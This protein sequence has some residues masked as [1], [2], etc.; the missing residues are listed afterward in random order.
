[1]SSPSV[2][3]SVTRA[4]PKG[5]PLSEKRSITDDK[6][7][8]GLNPSNQDGGSGKPKKR[9]KKNS[10]QWRMERKRKAEEHFSSMG[11]E[12]EEP[13]PFRIMTRLQKR[14]LESGL[15]IFDDRY[16]ITTG[17][18]KSRSESTVTDQTGPSQLNVTDHP[19]KVEKSEKNKYPTQNIKS[20]TCEI[21]NTKVMCT[22][23]YQRHM[24]GRKHL[25][26]VKWVRAHQVLSGADQHAGSGEPLGLYLPVMNALSNT[27]NDKLQQDDGNSQL[28]ADLLL[29]VLSKIQI[30]AIAS[31]TCALGAKIPARTSMA[32]PSYQPQLLLTRGSE[33]ETHVEMENPS[34]ERKTELA[35]AAEMPALKSMTGPSYEPHMLQTQ[36][37]EIKALVEMENSC[38]VTKSELAMAAEIPAP[39]SMVGSSYE[40]QLLQT[41]VSEIKAHVE[42]ENPFG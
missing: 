20:L 38:G 36:V 10:S 40:P 4:T 28:F 34:G 32:G 30:P 31:E 35:V 21:C 42:M 33:I 16:R 22:N 41:E 19:K 11:K 27:I 7:A 39:T 2:P 8:S 17:L 15:P 29:T 26:R 5:Q 37:S 23:H 14:R 18:Q 6:S 3:D 1:M 24:N 12:E 13:I 25:N 9:N